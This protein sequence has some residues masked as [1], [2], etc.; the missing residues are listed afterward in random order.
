MA[1]DGHLAPGDELGVFVGNSTSKNPDAIVYVLSVTHT[2]TQ[3]RPYVLIVSVS[4][5]VPR[6]VVER[7]TAGAVAIVREPT[8]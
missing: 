6:I 2:G 1:L 8:S 5:R 3:D 4:T 7:L